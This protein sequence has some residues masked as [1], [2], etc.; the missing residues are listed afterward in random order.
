MLDLDE[1]LDVGP[2]FCRG[3]SRQILLKQ[4][5]PINR[6]Q[7]LCIVKSPGPLEHRAQTIEP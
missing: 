5:V 2:G 7:F 4:T 6:G 1:V 3:V